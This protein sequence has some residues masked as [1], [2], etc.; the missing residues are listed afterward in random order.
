[1][2]HYFPKVDDLK[3]KAVDT[4]NLSVSEIERRATTSRVTLD[5][6]QVE[7]PVVTTDVPKPKSTLGSLWDQIKSRRNDS[8]I[9]DETTKENIT[10]EVAQPDVINTQSEVQP[11]ITITE[12]VQ[13]EITSSQVKTGFSAL[14][15]QI[16]SKRLEYGSPSPKIS[17]VGLATTESPQMLSPLKSKPSISNLFDDTEALF[18]DDEDIIT[19]QVIE[20]SSTSFVQ[21]NTANRSPGILSPEVINNIV[22]DPSWDIVETKITDKLV[23]INLK[24]LTGQAESIHF[25]TNHNHDF[26]YGI[27]V[28]AMRNIE[29]NNKFYSFDWKSQIS[30]HSIEKLGNIELKEIF[31]QDTSG[32]F[33]S[34][35]KDNKFFN[36]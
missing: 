25:I 5:E 3:G 2:S 34:I 29:N 11:E 21:E 7:P 36:K 15:D 10:Q 9:I 33:H 30:Q 20:G 13:P 12:E 14:F 32:N 23:K 8:N 26:N 16:K 27:D 18:G 4:T 35:Y 22:I 1:M 28:E 19:P 31:V 6:I 24:E 17:Q